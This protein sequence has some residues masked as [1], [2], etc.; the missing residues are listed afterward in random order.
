MFR[1]RI[2]FRLHKEILDTGIYTYRVFYSHD[3]SK[4]PLTLNKPNLNSV[5]NKKGFFT[6]TLLDC[7]QGTTQMMSV[8]NNVASIDIVKATDSEMNN[9][10]HVCSTE[11]KIFSSE[12]TVSQTEIDTDFSNEKNH[13]DLD[14]PN[15][16]AISDESISMKNSFLCSVL[17][18]A[19][20]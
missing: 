1:K 12:R 15:W 5:T 8:I 7:N 13:C 11:P 14:C 16:R 6:Y 2:K 9:D 19:P 4:Y 17:L 10:L 18:D 3:E 20:F